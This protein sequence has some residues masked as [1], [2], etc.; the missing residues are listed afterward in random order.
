ML[1]RRQIVAQILIK[2]KRAPNPLCMGT[3]IFEIKFQELNKVKKYD[4]LQKMK[5]VF[6][7]YFHNL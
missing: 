7:T 1:D 3:I 4:L 5:T 6:K 2:L